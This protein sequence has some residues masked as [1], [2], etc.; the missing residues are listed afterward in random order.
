MAIGAKMLG[1]C[2]TI[3]L[4]AVIVLEHCPFLEYNYGLA[5]EELLQDN[6]GNHRQC[7]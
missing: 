3:L 5:A 4:R 2:E 1:C 7:C 6:R